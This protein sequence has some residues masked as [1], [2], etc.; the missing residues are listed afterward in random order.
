MTNYMRMYTLTHARAHTSV[1]KSFFVGGLEGGG[2][3]SDMC[4]GN[5]HKHCYGFYPATVVT[6]AF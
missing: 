4:V 1:H 3:L 6:V 5:T 2:R